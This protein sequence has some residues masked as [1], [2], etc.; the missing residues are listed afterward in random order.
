MDEAIQ[1][2]LTGIFRTVFD[3]PDLQLTRAMTAHDVP[4]WDSLSHITLIV[5]VEREFRVSFLVDAL[6]KKKGV[7][8]TE[9][10]VSEQV[11]LMAG[12]YRRPPDEMRR[13]L[14]QRDLMAPMRSRLR[15][16]KVLDALKK[17]VRI[18]S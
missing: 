13:Y 18:E 14:E 15:E 12:R 11:G 9:G 6:A 3:E 17:E 1:Q 10:E 8:V 4:A 5:A 7:F 16:R 2:R